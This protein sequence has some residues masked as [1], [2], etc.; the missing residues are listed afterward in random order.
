[1]VE[2][3]KP[4]ITHAMLLHDSHLLVPLIP[5]VLS[6]AIGLSNSRRSIGSCKTRIEVSF[7]CMRVRIVIGSVRIELALKTRVMAGDEM[8]VMAEVLSA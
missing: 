5:V 3:L 2:R 1:M 4:I 7:F 6:R 8:S